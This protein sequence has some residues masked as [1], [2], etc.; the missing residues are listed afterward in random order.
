M[1]T[2]LEVALL[3]GMDHAENFSEL[4]R[5]SLPARHPAGRGVL[6]LHAGLDTAL[7]LSLVGEHKR[8]L[9]LSGCLRPS[10]SPCTGRRGGFS[11]ECPTPSSHWPAHF[12]RLLS[13]HLVGGDKSQ[14]EHGG[15]T[16]CPSGDPDS[17]P[18][19]RL[20]Q[21]PDGPGRLGDQMAWDD[22]VAR[23]TQAACQSARRKQERPCS[24]RG[25]FV[26]QLASPQLVQT[27][28]SHSDHLVAL[29]TC[30]GLW[31]QSLHPVVQGGCHVVE[32]A[33]QG[34]PTPP[35]PPAWL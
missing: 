33:S 12:P 28:D 2:S 11:P 3:S 14:S 27:R 8:L 1:V 29:L 30:K 32:A 35:S 22:P 4:S 17:G 23:V 5:A 10:W 13:P 7:S 31:A 24:L 34:P 26:G 15:Q 21:R 18:S 19:D 16:L 6:G 25:Y 20:A 9:P